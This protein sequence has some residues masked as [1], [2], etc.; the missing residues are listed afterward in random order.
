MYR[1][2]LLNPSQTHLQRIFWRDPPDDVLKTYE[3]HTVTYGTK[4]ASYLAINSVRDLAERFKLKFP[5]GAKAALNNI[6]VNDNR[7]INS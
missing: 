6:Y 4:S 7:C 1:Q 2:V 3:L 5:L